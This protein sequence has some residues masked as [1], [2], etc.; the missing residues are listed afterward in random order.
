ML[1]LQPDRVALEE[2]WNPNVYIDNAI[3]PPT[4]MSNSL[5]L[6]KDSKD[7]AYIVHSRTV[8]G[9]FHVRMGLPDFPFDIQVVNAACHPP[10]V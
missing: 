4:V 5:R 2:F 3:E 6:M 10:D 1:T 7:S 8:K 9:V